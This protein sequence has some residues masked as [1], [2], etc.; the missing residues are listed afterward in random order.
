MDKVRGPW[1]IRDTSD[2]YADFRH[3]KAQAAQYRRAQKLRQVLLWGAIAGLT[4]SASLALTWSAMT[5]KPW[6]RLPS[7]LSTATLSSGLRTAATQAKHYAAYPNC[8][9][10][11]AVGLAPA[12]RGQP[13]YWP[14]HDRDNDGIACEPYPRRW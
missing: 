6:T 8:A 11:R 2:P 9:A 12:Y 3:L 1:G 4:F 10:A 5:W 7:G 13:G 14:Q